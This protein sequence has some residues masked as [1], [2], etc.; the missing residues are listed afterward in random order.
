MLKEEIKEREDLQKANDQSSNNDQ[1]SCKKS[2]KPNAQTESN[3]K[4]D[5]TTFL[6]KRILEY[7]R[8]QQESM[9]QL[10]EIK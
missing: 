5:L 7:E 4:S 6:Q 8:K 2:A 9:N 10:D 1:S 3:Y